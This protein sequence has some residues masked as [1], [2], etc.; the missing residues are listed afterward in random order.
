[1][2]VYEARFQCSDNMGCIF[3]VCSS[4]KYGVNC[5]YPCGNCENNAACNSVDGACTAC[6]PGYL[7]PMCKGRYVLF[8]KI[9]FVKHLDFNFTNV[10]THRQLHML[11]RC[12]LVLTCKQ[13]AFGYCLM[14]TTY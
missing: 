9:D 1:M 3:S 10:I 13:S 12:E 4:G 5:A 8:P 14:I 11:K 6:V 2:N 7:V